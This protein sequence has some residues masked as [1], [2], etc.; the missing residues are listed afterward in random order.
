MNTWSPH[1][2]PHPEQIWDRRSR[3]GPGP[4]QSA[5]SWG[6]SWGRLQAPLPVSPPLLP[7]TPDP[8]PGG[9]LRLRHRGEEQGCGGEVGPEGLAGRGEEAQRGPP[10]PPDCVQTGE[11]GTPPPAQKA[12]E[13]QWFLL[14]PCPPGETESGSLGTSDGAPRGQV[15]LPACTTSSPCWPCG[16]QMQKNHPG[17]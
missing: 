3:P 11:W 16:S 13:W 9:R 17:L 5:P 15:A 10:G 2:Q 14:A 8:A 7:R 4:L 6:P 12:L 1:S